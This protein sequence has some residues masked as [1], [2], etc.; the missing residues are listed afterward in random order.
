MT[1]T[2]R[3]SEVKGEAALLPL[4]GRAFRGRNKGQ[5]AALG[6]TVVADKIPVTL[7]PAHVAKILG[8]STPYIE[9]A[10]QLTPAERL[11][12]IQGR[13]RL[14]DPTQADLLRAQ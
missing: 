10:L 5:L 2:L 7:L 12:V 9:R 6:A 8:V 11:L 3:P 1:T 4:D 13:R 14:D